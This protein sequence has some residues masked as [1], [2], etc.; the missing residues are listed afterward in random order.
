MFTGLIEATGRVARVERV[1]SGLRL[2]VQTPLAVE[3]SD[4]DSLA[5]NGVCL[6]IVERDEESAAFDVGPET[7]RVTALGE[8]GDGAVVNLERAMRADA[9]VGG[10]FVQGHVDATTKVLDIEPAAEFIWIWLALAA[11]HSVYVIP[12]GAI[13]LDGISLTIALLEDDRFAVQIVPYTW[14]HTN[15]SAR[16]PGDSV[17]V[18]FDL[19]GK[20]A[21]RAA[22]LA[23]A[24]KTVLETR[25]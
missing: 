10:H 20:Y 17:N 18:E 21:V 5:V 24:G 12:K 9:R 16:R 8:L 7:M 25:P 13:A 23:A 22:Q 14:A 2:R 1:P 4:G 19:L 11:A 6:T 3:L 15:L